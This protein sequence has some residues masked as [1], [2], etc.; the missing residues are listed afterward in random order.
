LG[1][2]PRRDVGTCLGVATRSG[3]ATAGTTVVTRVIDALGGVVPA[4][5]AGQTT[6]QTIYTWERAGT[7]R[8]ATAC[9]LLADAAAPKLGRDRWDLAAELAGITAPAPKRRR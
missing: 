7:V 9:L 1:L 3:R 6:P 4:A 8:L 2:P 5:A